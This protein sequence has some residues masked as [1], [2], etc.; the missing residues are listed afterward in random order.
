METSYNQNWRGVQTFSFVDGYF[1]FRL[2]INNFLKSS[3]DRNYLF[4]LSLLMG[5]GLLM[6]CK[7]RLVDTFFYFV[8][9]HS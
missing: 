6:N 8:A 5:H 1:C 9:F 4:V 2:F 3:Y 7:Y